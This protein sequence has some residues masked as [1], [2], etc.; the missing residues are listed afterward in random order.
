MGYEP[1]H[2]FTD[3]LHIDIQGAQ[4]IEVASGTVKK[5]AYDSARGYYIIVNHGSGYEILY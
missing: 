2:M 4:V 5:V 1:A 3:A